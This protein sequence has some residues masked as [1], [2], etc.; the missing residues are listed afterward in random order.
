[1]KT[2]KIELVF[3]EGEH[4]STLIVTIPHISAD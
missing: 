2:R 3:G 4:S 1:V